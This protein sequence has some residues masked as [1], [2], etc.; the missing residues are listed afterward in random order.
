ML[1]EDLIVSTKEPKKVLVI[2]G[3]PAGMEAARMAALS[4]RHVTL[5]AARP[6]LGGNINI[7]K[8]A[9]RLKTLADITIWQEQERYRLGVEVQHLC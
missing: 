2:G 3:G 4:G 8:L 6:K 5:L 7:S 9:P 1:A